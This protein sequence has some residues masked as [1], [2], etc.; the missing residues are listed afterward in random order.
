MIWKITQP[1]KLNLYQTNDKHAFMY[2]FVISSSMLTVLV[3]KMVYTNKE[4][5]LVVYNFR[6]KDN[7]QIKIL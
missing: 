3:V 7:E 5:D 4:K 2:I 1:L 6:N